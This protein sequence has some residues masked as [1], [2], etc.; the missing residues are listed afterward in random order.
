M[1]W[2]KNQA[3]IFTESGAERSRQRTN[4]QADTFVEGNEG[5]SMQ[6]TSRPSVRHEQMEGKTPS[7]RI[8]GFNM[9][10]LSP[11]MQRKHEVG[12]PMSKIVGRRLKRRTSSRLVLLEQRGK[13][14]HERDGKLVWRYEMQLGFVISPEV[15]IE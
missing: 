9:E 6:T 12:K 1:T 8:C 13:L 10:C 11:C 2:L 4:K 15:A 7:V 3:L 5:P 14:Q